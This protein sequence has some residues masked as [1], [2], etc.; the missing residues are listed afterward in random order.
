MIKQPYSMTVYLLHS[1]YRWQNFNFVERLCPLIRLLAYNIEV[2]ID[3]ELLMVRAYNT[4][5]EIT[6]ALKIPRFTVRIKYRI[7]HCPRTR[8]NRIRKRFT[9]SSAGT[10]VHE[11]ENAKKAWHRY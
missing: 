7:R 9:F 4:G 10:T 3:L 8:P 1:G 11:P 5:I 6:R 2:V